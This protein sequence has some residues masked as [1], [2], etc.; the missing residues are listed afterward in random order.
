MC[1]K[2]TP[3]AYKSGVCCFH[4]LLHI[5][6]KHA[7]GYDREAIRPGCIWVEHAFRRLGII[8][9]I[10]LLSASCYEGGEYLTNRLPFHC[11]MK[12]NQVTTSLTSLHLENY[13]DNLRPSLMRDLLTMTLWQDWYTQGCCTSPYCN[14]NMSLD[15][16]HMFTIPG[17]SP[18][19]PSSSSSFVFVYFV[20]LYCTL[21]HTHPCMRVVCF[22][23]FFCTYPSFLHA[24]SCVDPLLPDFWMCMDHPR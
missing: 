14:A 20:P 10:G 24:L 21:S 4:V 22:S 13:L 17:K 5:R 8:D 18:H 23:S 15:T 1:W 11:E 2:T 6:N 19:V 9:C 3:V 12:K 7:S 16:S